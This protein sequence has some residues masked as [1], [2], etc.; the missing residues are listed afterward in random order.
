MASLLNG[1]RRGVSAGYLRKAS[2]LRWLSAS[3]AG[4]EGI[5]RTGEREKS[6]EEV[7]PDELVRVLYCRQSD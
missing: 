3:T 7:T 1:L 4:R 6:V 2:G 5:V